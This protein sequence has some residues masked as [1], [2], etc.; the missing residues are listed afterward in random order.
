MEI[1]TRHLQ[2]HQ[3]RALGIVARAS[4]LLDGAAP[5]IGRLAQCRWEL[6]RTLRAYQIHKHRAVFD[7][8]IAGGGASDRVRLARQLKADCIA[9]GDRFRAYLLHWSAKNTADVWP[10]YRGAAHRMIAELRL[11]ID[12]ERRGIA[13]LAAGGGTSMEPPPRAAP[14]APRLRY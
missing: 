2:D 5:D 13:T 6:A 1:A 12:R 14:G 10:E 11:H 4:A 3:D 8:I 7:P 9:M